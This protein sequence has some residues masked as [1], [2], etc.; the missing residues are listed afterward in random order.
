MDYLLDAKDMRT[1]SEFQQMALG[2]VAQLR[3]ILNNKKS[4]LEEDKET[5]LKAKAKSTASANDELRRRAL[6]LAAQNRMVTL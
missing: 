5:H 6:K 2:K 1:D 4:A 3:L